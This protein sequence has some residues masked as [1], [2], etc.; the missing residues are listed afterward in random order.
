MESDADI[1]PNATDMKTI[2]VIFRNTRSLYM[3]SIG[4]ARYA[5]ATMGTYL[6]K[7]KENGIPGPGVRRPRMRRHR[8]RVI[9]HG[10]LRGGRKLPRVVDSTIDGL[11]RQLR[12]DGGTRRP[13]GQA[14]KRGE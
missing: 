11:K 8:V 1:A 12:K 3:A 10:I 9:S 2:T 7:N 6:V 14:D 13:N 4:G 5:A